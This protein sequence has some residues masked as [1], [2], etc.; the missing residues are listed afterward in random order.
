MEILSLI[1]KR[2]DNRE[3]SEHNQV[4]VKFIMG[5]V[6]LSY[7]LLINQFQTVHPQVIAASTIYVVLA[8]LFFIWI[9]VKPDKNPF[10]RIFGMLSDV[11]IITCIMLPDGDISTPLFGGY[12]FLTFGYGFRY[13]NRYLFGSAFLSILGFI[14]VI[15]HNEYW[16]E[17]TFLSYGLIVAIIILSIYVSKLISQLHKAVIEAESANRAKSQF[18]ANMSHEIR[19]PLNGVIGMSALISKTPLSAKQ[20]EF[21]STINASAKT[22]LTL[23]NDILDIS[24][25][26]AGKITTEIVDFDLHALINS[27]YMMFAPQAYEKNIIFNV[28]ISTTMP[29]LFKGDEQH[30]RQVI[31]NLIS[32]AIKFTN[33]GSIEIYVRQIDTINTHS[34]IHFEV[35]DTGIGIPEQSKP[36]LFDKFTQADESTTRKFGGTGLGMAIAKHLIE[37]MG[38]TIDFS[39]TLGKGSK[40]WFE[41]TLEEQTIIS[42]EKDSL[43]HFGDTNILFVNSDMNYI[44]AIE[45][46]LAVWPFYYEYATDSQKALDL[47]IDSDTKNKFFNIILVCK[48]FLDSDPVKFIHLVNRKSIYKN[49]AFILINDDELDF[50]ATNK[51]LNSGYTSIINSSPDRTVFYRALH[52]AVSGRNM[53]EVNPDHIKEEK[54][55]YTAN[56]GSLKNSRW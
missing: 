10:R 31:I 2:L 55:L 33:D 11:Y 13:G 50:N 1:K 54:S 19:T 9:I 20:K 43:T 39:S 56:R 3:D 29:F 5:V 40:F 12:L 21:S 51:I 4:G 35:I 6:W 53:N 25:I 26:E 42:E 24:K 8:P 22:L 15:T 46:H 16:L 28:H 32:N 34:I 45:K 17:Q 44:Q 18:L 36:K 47:I 37:T 38:G 48:K 7:V 52:A 30:I 27:C 49:R 41:L 14:F 23:I